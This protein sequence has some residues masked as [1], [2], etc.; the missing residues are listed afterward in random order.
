MHRGIRTLFGIA[1]AML[2]ALAATCAHAERVVLIVAGAE[3][4]IY[5][6][7]TLAMRLGY[8]RDEDLD[9]ELD[10]EASGVSAADALLAG[11]AQGV[12][13]AYD[14]TIDLQSRGKSV[15]AIVQFTS[16]PGEVELV[17]T[18]RAGEIRSP[19]DFAGR[20]LGVTGLGSST[21]FLTQYL[22]LTHGV[23]AADMRLVP[24]G[25]AESFITAMRSGRIDAGMTTEPTASRLVT[26]GEARVLVDLRTPEATQ[27]AL[28][29][30]YPF[31]C[32]Y[33]RTDWLATHREQAQKLANAFVKAL[34]FISTHSAAEIAAVLP[35]DYFAGGRAVY[36]QSLA[37]SK[38]MFIPDGVMP[39]DGPASVLKV[40]SAVNR[41]V[42]NKAINL[43]HTYTTLYVNAVK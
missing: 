40:L 39:A 43:S 13:G 14:H 17:A 25:S 16:A 36:V 21:N 32:L 10:N 3:K 29:G 5:L 6:P 22:A 28:G 38:S 2:A 26:A 27:Q 8:F 7:A 37:R 4:Q 18:S 12:I 24:V 34:R 41:Q 20:A 19:A 11:A 42:H 23:K 31:A 1:V 33:V 30:L 9:V 35:D 15:Q